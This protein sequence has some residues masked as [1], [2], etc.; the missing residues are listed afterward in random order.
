MRKMMMA[1][2][3]AAM[4][5]AATTPAAAGGD[6]SSGRKAQD[7]GM[8]Q[9]PHCARSLGTISIVEP[10]KQW[11]VD[12]QLGSPEAILKVF[13]Q[14]SGCFT[15]VNRGR[16]MASRNMERAMADNGELQRGSNM[17]KGQVRAADFF[18]EP[19]IVSS[20]NNS[21]GSNV[22]GAIGGILGRRGGLIGS[23]GSLAGG[24]NIKKG[25]ANVTLS[26]VNARTTEESVVE[27]YYRKTDVGFGAATSAGWWGGF[28]AAGGGGYQNTQIG[29]VIVL[30]YL[31]AY[32][33]LVRQLGGG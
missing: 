10:D 23:V 18:L 24:I 33:K 21:G 4:M 7:A 6:K 31:D 15:L 25:E 26:V 9:M 17:G 12:Y 28:A 14:E 20:N 5:M 29:Q 11:W 30:A 13:V 27:G 32:S 3:T 8:A 1:A 22:G 16:S 2:A 19:N